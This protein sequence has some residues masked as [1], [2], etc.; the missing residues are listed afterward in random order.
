MMR[1]I[2]VENIDCG[3]DFKCMICH[4]KTAEKRKLLWDENGAGYTIVMCPGCVIIPD[5][6]IENMLNH[7]FS[8]H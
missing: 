1:T 4:T 7:G 6:D 2:T 5:E 3:K 8:V